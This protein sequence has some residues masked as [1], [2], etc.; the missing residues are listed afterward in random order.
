MKAP[1]RKSKGSLKTVSLDILSSQAYSRPRDGSDSSSQESNDSDSETDDSDTASLQTFGNRRSKKQRRVRCC[2]AGVSVVFALTT[3]A[4]FI[5]LYAFDLGAYSL[6]LYISSLGEPSARGPNWVPMETPALLF[7]VQPTVINA[8]FSAVEFLASAYQVVRSDAIVRHI[9]ETGTN[10]ARWIGYAISAPFMHVTVALLSGIIDIYV[11]IS[12]FALTSITMVFG[13]YA[14]KYRSYTFFLWG[15]VPWIA[16]WVVIM[17]AFFYQVSGGASPPGFV[18]AIIF[19][20][21]AL[22]ASFAV[23]CAVSL[24]EQY[25]TKWHVF[26]IG[27]AILSFTS[28]SLLVWITFGG[29]NMLN[30]DN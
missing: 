3:A 8:I 25:S 24:M 2:Y 9:F 5:L 21:F 15:C 26:E 4:L 6:D 1:E 18:Y 12:V 16:Q 20:I 19:I 29:I 28:K 7:S 11:L 13:I 10:P 23:L 30:A 22:D 14:E 27:Y 17:W